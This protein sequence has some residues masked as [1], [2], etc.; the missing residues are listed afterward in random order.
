MYE[1]VPDFERLNIIK[2][3]EEGKVILDIPYLTE[4]TASA[5][6]YPAVTAL[7]NELFEILSEDLKEIVSRKGHRVPKHIDEYKH[8]RSQWLLRAYP[9]AQLEAIVQQGLMP[10]RV[11]VGKT[12]IIFLTYRKKV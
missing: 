4:E 6:F 1:L 3:D 9:L 12:P 11:D 8:C 5:V 2:R 10:Y 7:Q